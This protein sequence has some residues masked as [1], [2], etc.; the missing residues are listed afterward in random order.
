MIVAVVSFTLS[1]VSSLNFRDVYPLVDSCIDH[2]LSILMQVVLSPSALM[3]SLK[4]NAIL[5][6]RFKALAAR[7]H[8]PFLPP[9]GSMC[10]ITDPASSL[11]CFVVKVLGR[12]SPSPARCLI[13]G[14]VI[15][16]GGR[17]VGFFDMSPSKVESWIGDPLRCHGK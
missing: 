9:R 10:A 12:C 11:T 8:L 1:E 6:P 3:V 15:G 16:A 4:K 13:F 2:T 7:Y 17:A 14:D 5:S